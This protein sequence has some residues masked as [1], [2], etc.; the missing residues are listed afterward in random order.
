MNKFEKLFEKGEIDK[1][2][3]SLKKEK[4]ILIGKRMEQITDAKMATVNKG[5]I[6]IS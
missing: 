1:L 2:R 5:N 3:N 6:K 4:N